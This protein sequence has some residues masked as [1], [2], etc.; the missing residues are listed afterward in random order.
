M[1][2]IDWWNGPLSLVVIF[3]ALCL[4]LLTWSIA[5]VACRACHS[6]GT[7]FH[8]DTHAHT[9]TQTERGRGRERERERESSTQHIGS[10]ELHDKTYALQ[11]C[12]EGG[13]KGHRCPPLCC[14]CLCFFF[15]CKKHQVIA[16]RTKTIKTYKNKKERKKTGSGTAQKSKPKGIFA[17]WT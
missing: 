8:C 12:Q 3:F 10:T 17:T 15:S 1:A 4:L 11:W 6:S 16:N 9:H 5:G 2:V 13:K 14:Q 7:F